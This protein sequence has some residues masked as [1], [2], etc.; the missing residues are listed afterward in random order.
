MSKY[1]KNITSID[2]IKVLFTISKLEILS[3]TE[4]FF[5]VKVTQKLSHVVPI[6]TH[7]RRVILTHLKKTSQFDPEKLSQID[8]N[9]T[10]TQLL[11]QVYSK[12][13]FI[14]P[15]HKTESDRLKFD[16]DSVFESF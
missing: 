14:S 11:R 4:N 5:R 1:F 15:P 16:H 13:Q 9:A 3:L 12:S 6:M 10:M 2:K 8:S 7:I